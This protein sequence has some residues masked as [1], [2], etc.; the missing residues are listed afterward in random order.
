MPIIK[1]AFC[2]DLKYWSTPQRQ[3]KGD[4]PPGGL[5]RSCSFPYMGGVRS[6]SCWY[7]KISVRYFRVSNLTEDV[8]NGKCC[9]VVR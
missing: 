2:N 5:V 3:V 6:R 7:L 1:E 9:G 8:N 4:R